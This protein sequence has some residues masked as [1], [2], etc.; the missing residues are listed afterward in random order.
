MSVDVWVYVFMIIWRSV[1]M[2]FCLSVFVHACVRSS[3]CARLPACQDVC[4]PGSL[5]AY[6]F[7]Y[8]CVSFA[9]VFNAILEVH[10]CF[11]RYVPREIPREIPRD[12][13]RD[14]GRGG[15]DDR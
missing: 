15:G 11:I 6:L 13:D 3:V 10:V 7:V 8:M 14:Y 1:C 9:A 12:R 4:I 5:C 2:F